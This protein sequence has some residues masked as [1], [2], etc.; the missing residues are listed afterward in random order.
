MVLHTEAGTAAL[1]DK[2]LTDV[3]CK[4]PWLSAPSPTEHLIQW[5]MYVSD[6]GSD[7]ILYR[8]ILKKKLNTYPNVLFVDSNCYMHLYQLC[9]KSGIRIVDH[10]APL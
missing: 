7:Q 4:L 9:F 10:W 1:L 5:Y 8:K 3:G 6:G 2:Q